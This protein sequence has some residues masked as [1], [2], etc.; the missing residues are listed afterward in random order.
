[1]NVKKAADFHQKQNK[2]NVYFIF[3]F[4]NIEEFSQLTQNQVNRLIIDNLR[5]REHKLLW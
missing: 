4:L 5:F 1:M 3:K 2:F